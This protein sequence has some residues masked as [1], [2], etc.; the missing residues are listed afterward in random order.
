MMYHAFEKL[1]TLRSEKIEIRRT[2]EMGWCWHVDGKTV[3]IRDAAEELVGQLLNR[4][5]SSHNQ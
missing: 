3:S 2:R 1:N 5:A 4:I